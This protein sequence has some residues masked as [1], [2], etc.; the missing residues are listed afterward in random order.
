MLAFRSLAPYSKN[1]E[2]SKSF[3]SFNKQDCLKKIKNYAVESPT[4]EVQFFGSIVLSFVE[5]WLIARM[6]NFH[7]QG[8]T[9][10]PVRVSP[11][12]LNCSISD[13]S[14]LLFLNTICMLEFKRTLHLLK[15]FSCKPYFSQVLL[16]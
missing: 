14:S 13:H 16:T 9:I 12:L 5:T 6:Y 8:G 2:L 11:C 4:L 10:L 7:I 15:S 1:K 3:V